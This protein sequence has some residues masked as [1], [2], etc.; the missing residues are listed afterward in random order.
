MSI[1]RFRVWHLLV[2]T[3]TVGVFFSGWA[4]ALKFV[5]PEKIVNRYELASSD[6]VCDAVPDDIDFSPETFHSDLQGL[7]NAHNYATA[8]WLLMQASNAPLIESRGIAYYAVDPMEKQLPGIDKR[9]DHERDFVLPEHKGFGDISLT[10]LHF[11][12]KFA[13]KYNREVALHLID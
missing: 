2:V 4:A 3:A 6:P 8:M 5:P 12:I 10:W 9:F 7:V 1:V 13:E 11:R